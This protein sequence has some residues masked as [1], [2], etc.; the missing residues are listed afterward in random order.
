LYDTKLYNLGQD[1]NEFIIANPDFC[2]Y[3]FYK[4]IKSLP[5]RNSNRCVVWKYEGQ[6]I[7][8]YFTAEWINEQK[9]WEVDLKLDWVKN[10]AIDS[11]IV[12][13]DIIIQ[14]WYDLNYEMSLYLDSRFNLTAD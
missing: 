2:N 7:A 13:E 12:F 5:L 11:S 9:Y 8:K 3:Q 14:D 1:H 4:N 10:P 6:W